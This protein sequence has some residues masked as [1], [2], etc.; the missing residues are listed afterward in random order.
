MV[1]QNYALFPNL[2][3][4]DNVAFGLAMARVPR[5]ELRQRTQEA[6]RMVELEK[7]GGR[8]PS[9][10]SGGQR[11]RVALARALVPNPRILL[12]DEPL[13]ALD[14]R[15]RRSLRE[16][17]RRIQRETGVTTL[18]VTHDQEEALEISDRIFLMNGGVI[19]QQGSPE[20]IYARPASE[21]AARF[22]GHCNIL[23]SDAG[24]VFPEGQGDGG[25]WGIRPES[26][27]I[28]RDGQSLPERARGPFRAKVR[29][30]RLLG[31]VIRYDLDWGGQSL[32]ADELNRGAGPLPEGLSVEIF[33]D[34]EALLKLDARA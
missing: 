5:E 15:I 28:R 26:V 31:N 2:R 17:I 30:G 3:V 4:F 20:E 21:F 22:M 33:F 7:L 27:L 29:S 25:I 6:L 19:I 23:D 14:A 32:L 24:K 11:Q 9:E 18:F 13:S 8:Y 10:L 1:F 34:E 12:L 16:Q